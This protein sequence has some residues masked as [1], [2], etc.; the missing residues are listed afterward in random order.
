MNFTRVKLEIFIPITHLDGLRLALGQAGAGK[1]GN[2]DHCCSVSQVQG[3]WRPLEGSAPYQGQTGQIETAMEAK[4]EVTCDHNQ[5][6]AVLR[7]IRAAHPY[8]EPVIQI[9]PL[10]NFP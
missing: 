4:V 8:E 5:L 3:Y 2:Y 9:I 7:A 10:L 1:I 6:E